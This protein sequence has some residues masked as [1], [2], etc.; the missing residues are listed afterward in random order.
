MYLRYQLLPAQCM[1]LIKLNYITE[2]F[3]TGSQLTTSVTNTRRQK[4]T[5]KFQSLDTPWK[6]KKKITSKPTKLKIYSENQILN[7]SLQSR[8]PLPSDAPDKY[9]LK[10]KSCHL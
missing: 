4:F 8:I 7:F 3:G 1:E 10:Q 2:Q 5:I 6:K 9:I